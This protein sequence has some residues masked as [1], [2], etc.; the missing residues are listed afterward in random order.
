MKSKATP[1]TKPDHTPLSFR[2][3]P[4][5]FL[6]AAASALFALQSHA[7]AAIIYSG[8]ESLTFGPV[9]A[10]GDQL[11]IVPITAGLGLTFGVIRKNQAGN[12]YGAVYPSASGL[13]PFVQNAATGHLGMHRFASG[14]AITAGANFNGSRNELVSFKN[15]LHVGGTWLKD[16][17]GLAGFELPNGDLGWIRLEWT[18]TD[19]D[20]SPNELI[21]MDWAYDTTPGETIDAGQTSSVPE[22][23]TTAL[24]ALAGAGAAFLRRRRQEETACGGAAR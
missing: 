14:D 5:S 4:S 13:V 15:G 12:H 19:S 16:Q 20:P 23:T 11:A 9:G 22:P 3:H 17:T 24:L 18:T 7:D 10:T 6:P 21:A 1:D 8:P 2:L